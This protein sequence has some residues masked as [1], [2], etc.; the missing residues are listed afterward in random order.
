M[1]APS[2]VRTC[3]RMSEHP[4]TRTHVCTH[5]HLPVCLHSPCFTLLYIH[6]H[7]HSHRYAHTYTQ[8]CTHPPTHKDTHVHP[9][10]QR[11]VHTHPHIKLTHILTHTCILT[12]ISTREP[13]VHTHSYTST[14]SQSLCTYAHMYVHMQR[15]I[16]S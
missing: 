3:M 16:H 9:H 5:R 13:S 12:Q 14:D 7:M 8:V 15:Q 2:H 4:H 11:C 10:I 6:S 1:H